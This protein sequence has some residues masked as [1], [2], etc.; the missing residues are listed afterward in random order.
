[1]SDP[2]VVCTVEEVFEDVIH[3]THTFVPIQ[4]SVPMPAAFVDVPSD[5]KEIAANMR[6]LTKNVLSLLCYLLKE[7]IQ[8]CTTAHCVDKCMS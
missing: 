8:L 6:K 5:K 4:M 1:M 3:W 2:F 7:T